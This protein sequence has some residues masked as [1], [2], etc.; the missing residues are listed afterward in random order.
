MTAVRWAYR[1]TEQ[2]QVEVTISSPRAWH[3]LFIKF[4]WEST[5]GDGGRSQARVRENYKNSSRPKNNITKA[6]RATLRTLK[7]NSP[8]Y[9][10]TKAMI[11]WFSTLRTTNRRS[12]PFLRFHHIEDWPGI[13]LI[14]QNEKPHLL[15]YS[16]V[17]S[18]SWEASWNCS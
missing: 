7:N 9:R 1:H 18:P 11:P 12:P 4:T 15:T 6:E 3:I 10:Q 8:S 5:C 17:Q 16:M 14:R 2:Q 13:L